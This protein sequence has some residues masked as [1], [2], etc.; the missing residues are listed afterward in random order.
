MQADRFAEALADQR[1]GR[2]QHLLHAGSALRSFVADHDDVARLDLARHDRVH[3][4]G[5]G[6]EHARRT[7]DRRILEAGDLGHAAFGREIALED[8]EVALRVH[9]LVE[10]ADHVL[11][12]ARR[13][14][15]VRQLLGHGAAG[16]RHAVAVQQA[17]L[18]QHLQHLRHAARAMEVDRD[19]LA[20]GL[21]VAQ[22]RAPSGG[23]ARSRRWS[24]A[25]RPRT[26]SRGSAAPRWSS[27][28]WPSPARSRSRST[29]A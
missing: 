6:V 22:H 21:Q 25:P 14:G 3:H 16:D 15:H 8:R 18:E 7:G 26:R 9:R 10:R 19:V 20:R 5:L 12:G 29:C 4:L 11:V 13:V 17:R 23:R 27:R 2:R 24:T 28:R 1:R